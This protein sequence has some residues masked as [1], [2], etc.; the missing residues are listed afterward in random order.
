MLILLAVYSSLL[1]IVYALENLSQLALIG[2]WWSNRLEQIKALE[3]VAAG[4][5]KWVGHFIS[6]EAAR[7]ILGSLAWGVVMVIPFAVLAGVVYVFVRYV[8]EYLT[9]EHGQKLAIN[10][11]MLVAVSLMSLVLALVTPSGW[12]WVTYW[13]I[14]APVAV[15]AWIWAD[16]KL[17]ENSWI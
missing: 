6:N 17:S 3:K 1:S 15:L 11:S 12:L 4:F 14:Y 9:E 7:N 13:L 10:V 5:E 8:G 16:E 2:Q